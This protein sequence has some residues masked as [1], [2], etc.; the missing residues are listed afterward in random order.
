MEALGISGYREGRT[1]CRAVIVEHLDWGGRGRGNGKPTAV[2]E[3]G[4]GDLEGGAGIREKEAASESP[5]QKP[6]AAVVV[7][8]AECAL[9]AEIA[10]QDKVGFS[11]RTRSCGQDFDGAAAGI[12]K[13]RGFLLQGTGKCRRG[14]EGHRRRINGVLDG[15]RVRTK[16]RSDPHN[17]RIR[18]RHPGCNPCQNSRQSRPARRRRC[19]RNALT[20]QRQQLRRPRIRGKY[21]R[22]VGQFINPCNFR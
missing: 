1:E 20:H 6:V 7:E 10:R 17:L 22:R 3:G 13:R 4:V 16:C 15:H 18:F 14:R 5:A 9:D 11:R 19:L 21:G 8:S 2:V 12:E